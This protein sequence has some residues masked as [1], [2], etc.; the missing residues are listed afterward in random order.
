MKSYSK[1]D[2]YKTLKEFEVVSPKRLDN[3]YKD[4]VKSG[5]SFEKA[6]VDSDLISQDNLGKII[7]DMLGI[8]FIKLTD[9][10][11]DKEVMFKIPETVAKR[12]NLVAYKKDKS[13]VHIASSDYSNPTIFEFLKK[14]F[15]ENLIFYLT[16]QKDIK[17]AHALYTQD[18]TKI[19]DE[20]IAEGSSAIMGKPNE[21]SIIKI[22]D[23]IIKHAYQS[24]ASDIHIEPTDAIC[25]IRFR[26]DGI[27]HDIVTIPLELH[28]QIV[29]RIKV[30]S[31]LR[32][33]EHQ[34]PQDGKI[35]Y[36]LEEDDL[37]IRVSIVPITEGEKI[38]MRLL[39]EISRSYSINDLGLSPAAL[40]RL[41]NSYS[42]PNGMILSTG[43]TGSGKTTT[44]YAVLKPLNQKEVNIMTIEDPVEYDIER[45]NQIQ[46]NAKTNLTFASGLRSIVRQDPDIILV[47]EIRDDETANISINAA[48]TGHLVLSSLHTN[49]AATS[50]P[51]LHDLGVEP[52]L[53][54]STVNLI[55]AQRLVRTICDNCRISVERHGKQ[56]NMKKESSLAQKYLDKYGI[57]RIYKGKGCNVCHDT[58]YNGRIGIFEVLEVDDDIREAIVSQKDAHEIAQI[59]IKNGM[60][61]MM[62]DGI[63]KVKEGITTMQEILRVT[64]V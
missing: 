39:S 22:V 18:I 47:G 53:V 51:R 26:I 14:R 27:M 44:L 11:I 32:T 21:S 34:A 52:F 10:P 62:E 46:V 25:R 45:V 3:L 49:D 15:S 20:I 64:K 2:L 40:T 48:M 35:T 9:T 30:L 59:A 61:T 13:G 24:R 38:V 17:T 8:H 29:T 7:A 28:P 19:F 37:D 55:I 4:A 50:F 23:T 31:R 43:P 5:T 41:Q 6:L 16:S 54:A 36:E 57:K 58:G 12:Q 42:K 63:N 60:E 1:E 56:K 33:D